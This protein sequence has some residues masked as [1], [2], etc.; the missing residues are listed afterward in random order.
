LDSITSPQSRPVE[1]EFLAHILLPDG[2][3]VGEQVAPGI[4]F[5]YESRSMLQLLPGPSA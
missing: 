3:T 4:A 5:A 2:S 1:Q